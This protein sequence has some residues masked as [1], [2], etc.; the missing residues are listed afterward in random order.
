[1][2][3]LH[4]R[5]ET[6]FSISTE[7]C[8]TLQL[9]EVLQRVVAHACRLM[10]AR[11]A[12][13]LLIDKDNSVLRPAATYGASEAYLAL[14]DRDVAASFTGEVIKSGRPLYIP[15]VRKEDRFRLSALA[16]QE[17]L[18]TL[19][20]VPLRTK[21]DIIGA[22]NIY[23]PELR[24]FDES[25]IRLLTLLASQSAIAIENARLHA[26]EM[27]ARE[28]L[29][30]SE[31]L[32]ALGKLSAGLAHELRNPLNTV[33]MLMYAMAQELP[34]EN[35]LCND[36]RIVQGE[37]RRMSLL[38]EQFL[39][40]ARPRPPHFQRDRLDEIMEETLLLIGP[41]ARTRGVTIHKEWEKG[42]PQVWVDGAQIKQV[43][44]NLLL[45]ALQAMTRGG[46]LTVRLHVSGGS[47]LASIADE[48]G[49]IPPEVRENLFEP[50]FTTKAGGTGLG[51]SISQRI[52]E[53]HNGRLRL[54]SQPDV[55]TTAVVRLPL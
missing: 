50:F 2:N 46:T 9:D 27:E 49:G 51:L 1:M 40:F 37:L 54:F 30:Q 55:G 39:E 47:L 20:S 18:C 31:K 4:D 15:D 5:L 26:D 29:R 25:D 52:V 43:F 10:D 3:A 6:L 23:T 38:I 17:G 32:A 11:I 41:E 34:P 16:R 24:H 33:S 7:I 44:L 28:R 21:N 14:P 36:L 48:G 35:S 22:L 13:L 8:S 45:N 53:G 42:L 19:V 12:S